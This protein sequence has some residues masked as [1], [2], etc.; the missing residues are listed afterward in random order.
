VSISLIESLISELTS[1][2]LVLLPEMAICSYMASQAVWKYADDCSKDTSAWTMR[3]AGFTM[4]GKT[5]IYARGG[6]S[7]SCDLKSEKGEGLKAVVNSQNRRE[8]MDKNKLIEMASSFVETSD[9]NYI[10]NEMALSKNVSGLKMFEAPI[11]AFGEAED[12]Y[13]RKLKDKNV[14]GD[15]FLLPQEWLREAKTVISFFL[16]FTT[17]VKKGNIKDLIWPS[18]EWL[19]ARYEGQSFINKFCQ[20]LS[21]ELTRTGNKSVVPSLDDRFW[22]KTGD[23]SHIDNL[24]TS[25][26]S[27]RHVA[28]V[29]GLGTFGLSKGL[30]TSKGIAGRFGSIVTELYVSPDKREYGSIYEYCSMCGEC[31]EKCPVRAI[32]IEEGKNNKLCA[33]FLDETV[34]KFRPRYGCGKCQ[35]GVPCESFIPQ[36]R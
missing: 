30:I 3:M 11:F 35:V 12:D 25:N 10:T 1:P 26:W 28:F 9:A 24:Y 6:N 7:I 36:A 15:H 31:G 22:S 13:F 21:S 32:S 2:D 8:G 17:E 14:I 34:E 18:N 33:A 27:E 20:Y 19:H 4:N 5:K 29:C 16:P 23:N